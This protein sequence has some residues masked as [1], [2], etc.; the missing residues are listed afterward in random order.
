MIDRLIKQYEPFIYNR[1][2]L[3]AL[4]KYAKVKGSF[5]VWLTKFRKRRKLKLY[6]DREM[7]SRF[8]VAEDCKRA[9]KEYMKK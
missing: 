2:I 4:Y 9:L 7:V 8:G 3:I 1:E 5:N 6:S